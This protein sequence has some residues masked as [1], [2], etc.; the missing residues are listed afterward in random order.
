MAESGIW[1]PV[2]VAM[3]LDGT[4]RG[5]RVLRGQILTHREGAA[6][7]REKMQGQAAGPRRVKS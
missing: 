7:P 6:A 2:A 1:E 4:S 5:R 3:R